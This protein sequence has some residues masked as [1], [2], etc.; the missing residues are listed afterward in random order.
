MSRTAF[1]LGLALLSW[2]VAIPVLLLAEDPGGL[3]DDK[4]ARKLVVIPAG[5]VIDRDLFAVGEIVEI[6]GTVNGDVYAVGGQILVDGTINGELGRNVTVVAANLELMPSALIH[7]NV[8]A[9]GAN[10]EAGA[11]I[12]RDVKI[13]AAK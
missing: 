13:A 2:C 4:T 7:G 10:V 1:A 12:Q 3:P 11:L 6:S 8:V 9:A 5:Q